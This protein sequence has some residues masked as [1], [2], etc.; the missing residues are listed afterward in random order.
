MEKNIIVDT[1]LG[2]V[3][4][5]RTRGVLKF[6]GI[7]YAAPP[8]GE[9]RFSPPAP[10]EPWNGVLDATEY[11][12]IAPQPPSVLL[13]MFGGKRKQSEADCLTLNIWK[14]VADQDKRPVMV[15][16]HGGAFIIGSGADLDGARLARRGNVIIVSVNYR[17][18]GLGFCYIPGKTANVGLLDQIAA[19]KWVNDNIEAFGGDPNN[20]TIFGESAG[21]V[22]VCT[23]MAMPSA[24]GLFHRVIAQSGACHPMF[25]HNLRRKEASEQLMSK[26]SIKE[27]DIEALRKVPFEKLIKAD[28]TNEAI[29]RGSTF[30]SNEP[31]LGPVIDGSTLPEHPLNI[32]RNGYAKGIELLIGTNEDEL[33]LWSALN[34][35]APKVDEGKMIRSTTTLMKVL[36]QDENKGKQ[37]INIYQQAREGKQSTEPRDIIDAYLT[38]FAFRIPSIRL[39]EVQCAHQPNIFMYLFTWKSPMLGGKLGSC[40]ALELPFVFGLLSKKDIGIV[41]SKSQETEAISNHMMDSWTSF[42]R[43]GNPN[44][45][46]I[47][48]WPSYGV[49]KRSTMIFDKEIKVVNGPLDE[50][51]AAWDGIL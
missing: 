35:N 42:A 50:E 5:Y 7:P 1:K 15:W 28:P 6:K 51:R 4:G 40:H 26:L 36:G 31:T 46:G 13:A 34:P 18:G 11:G 33:K 44:H 25:Y 9:L 49:G 32:M 43:T 39:A 8:V 20:I 3:R 10:K 14:P 41:P 2:K 30:A 17:L 24:K 12:P 29:E 23:L 38:D 21:S 22:S 47:P 27:G 37:M 48:E 16:I 45:N 19:L